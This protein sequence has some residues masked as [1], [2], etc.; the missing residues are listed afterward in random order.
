MHLSCNAERILLYEMDNKNYENKAHIAMTT[1]IDNKEVPYSIIT[2]Y[3]RP[4]VSLSEIVERSAN[5]IKE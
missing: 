1:F 4:L 5:S 3:I 2:V